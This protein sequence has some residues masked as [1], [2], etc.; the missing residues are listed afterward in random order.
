MGSLIPASAPLSLAL[1]RS[2][3]LSLYLSVP[4]P[5]VPITDAPNVTVPLF[6]GIDRFCANA[7]SRL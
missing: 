4:A 3:S 1:S 6:F 2:L 7:S 5:T